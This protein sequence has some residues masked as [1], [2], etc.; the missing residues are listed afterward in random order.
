[1]QEIANKD[2]A[3]EKSLDH[4]ETHSGQQTRRRGLLR[5]TLKLPTQLSSQQA[6]TPTIST[7]FL[8]G[9]GAST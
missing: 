4:F 9:G 8:A 6:G 2:I 5:G 7:R 1:M 3:L